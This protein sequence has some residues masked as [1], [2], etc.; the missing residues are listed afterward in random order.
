MG[1]DMVILSHC[2]HKTFS[3]GT[4]SRGPPT[5]LWSLLCFE[6]LLLKCDCKTQSVNYEYDLSPLLER[7]VRHENNPADAPQLQPA[8]PHSYR[9][10]GKNSRDPPSEGEEWAELARLESEFTGEKH[11]M[12]CDPKS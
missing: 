8:L 4:R 9:E 12:A 5:L 11:T 7:L 2:F 1:T 10:V 6:V 3:T